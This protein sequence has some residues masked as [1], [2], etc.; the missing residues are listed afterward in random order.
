MCGRLGLSLLSD[1]ERDLQLTREAA[2]L[3]EAFAAN[4]YQNLD[5]RPTQVL[6]ILVQ[7]ALGLRLEPM[8][9][10]W[11][12]TWSK[13][14]L[15]NART[16]TVAT[17]AAW[18]TAY[19]ERRCVVPATLYYE[20][21]KGATDKAEAKYAFRDKSGALLLLAGLWTPEPAKDGAQEPHFVVL[22]RTMVLHAQVHERTPVMLTADD[23]RAWA[24]PEAPEQEV[25][26][27]LG[28]RRDDDLVVREVELGAEK[29]GAG[30]EV[31]APR[32]PWPWDS[33]N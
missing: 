26:A 28:S 24:D 23:A 31:A 17:K 14:L 8:R 7:G 5:V 13:Q 11:R 12:P 21:K 33:A 32:E 27:L 4:R 9:W 20:W 6:P 1:E 2:W 15:I 19:R 25:A 18:R 30:P 3:A 10:G 29:R 16:E 22:T